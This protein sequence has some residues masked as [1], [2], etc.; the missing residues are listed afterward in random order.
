MLNISSI[1]LS[2]LSIPKTAA[3]IP[4]SLD[5][6]ILEML[7]NFRAKGRSLKKW[8]YKALEH[9]NQLIL[10]YG[11]GK[12]IASFDNSDKIKAERQAR[13]TAISLLPPDIKLSGGYYFDKV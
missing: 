13:L 4:Q 12:I 9:E 7:S 10:L 11:N 2:S 8:N 6:K 1:A 3:R 5:D